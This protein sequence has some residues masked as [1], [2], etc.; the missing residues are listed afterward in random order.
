MGWQ[1]TRLIRTG[2]TN[3]ILHPQWQLD[4]LLFNMQKNAE[5]MHSLTITA[6]SIPFKVGMEIETQIIYINKW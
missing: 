1:T 2:Q 5:N 3:H 4:T 6:L